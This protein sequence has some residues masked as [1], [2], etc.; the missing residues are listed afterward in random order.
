MTME[1][2]YFRCLESHFW[3]CRCWLSGPWPRFNVNLSKQIPTLL[4]ISASIH[5]ARTKVSPE[6]VC[7]DAG[8]KFSHPEIIVMSFYA[9][10]LPSRRSISLLGLID[11]LLLIGLWTFAKVYDCRL[12]T[13]I[14]WINYLRI[15]AINITFVSTQIGLSIW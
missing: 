8:T 10:T 7:G 12:Q 9:L 4:A 13:L 2:T 14:R 5:G 6:A 11:I 1:D 3:L 15:S